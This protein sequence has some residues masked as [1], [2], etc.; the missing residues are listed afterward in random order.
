MGF[1][2]C[3]SFSC[4]SFMGCLC[5]LKCFAVYITALLRKACWSCVTIW[6][7]HSRYHCSVL[8]LRMW[9]RLCWVLVSVSQMAVRV[10]PCWWCL[11]T[12]SPCHSPHSS[13]VSAG[14]T[15]GWGSTDTYRPFTMVVLCGEEADGSFPTENFSLIPPANLDGTVH[16]STF[17][18]YRSLSCQLSLLTF[19]T[20]Q[21]QHTEINYPNESQNIM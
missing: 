7:S 13:Q 12:A 3:S 19:T 11:R 2:D 8:Y 18:F 9:W 5:F 15:G 4:S 21:C 16:T 6:C 14:W 17:L 10:S 1:E 20:M